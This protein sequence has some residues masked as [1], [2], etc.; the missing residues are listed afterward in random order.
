MEVCSGGELFDA[1]VDEGGQGFSERDAANVMRQMFGGITYMHRA[2]FCHRD[3]KPENFLLR[4]KAPIAKC[5]VKVCDFGL[6]TK[7]RPEKPL[8]T[9]AGTPY[10]VAPE[11][12]KGNY[13]ESCDLWSLAV[14]MYILLC[15]YPPFDGNGDDALT[16]KLVRKGDYSFDESEWGKISEDA[17]DL[18]RKLL[19]PQSQRLTAEQALNH[20]WI[21]KSAPQAKAAVVQDRILKNMKAFCGN[22]K[23]KKAALH[24]IANRLDDMQ[25]KELKDT[26]SSL[27]VNKDGVV[28]LQELQTG[29]E[30]FGIDVHELQ[31]FMDAMD[32]DGNGYIEYTEFLAASLDKKHYAEEKICWAAFQVFDRDNSGEISREELVK[33]LDDSTVAMVLGSSATARVMS[34]CDKDGDGTISFEEFMNLMRR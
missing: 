34:E 13:T 7:F 33:V 27:D 15:G 1:I 26:F 4:E 8:R 3:I 6:A 16:L 22:N 5:V 30:K 32:T 10:Y 12:L 31:D 25:I 23:L 21:E 9:K 20:V 2:R 24:I 17:K 29:I 28:T 14:I 11:V 19:V 18:I